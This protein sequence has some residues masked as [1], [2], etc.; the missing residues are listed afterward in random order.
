MRT[1]LTL[2]DDVAKQVEQLRRERGEGL[3]E[4]I[5]TILRAGIAAL[6]SKGKAATPAAVF[7]TE[8]VS[9]GAVRLRNLDNIDEVLSFGEGEAYR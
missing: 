7:E 8:S 6:S 4:T 1:T 2:E 9:L 3:K 5:N